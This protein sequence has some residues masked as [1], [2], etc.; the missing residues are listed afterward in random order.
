MYSS[1]FVL[2]YYLHTA[3]LKMP[4][5]QLHPP[6]SKEN[7]NE[8]RM[9]LSGHLAVGLIIFIICLNVLQKV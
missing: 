9:C 1:F 8:L 3:L 7:Q 4:E 6:S 2:G 5:T